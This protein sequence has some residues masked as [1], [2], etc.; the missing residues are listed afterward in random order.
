MFGLVIRLPSEEQLQQALLDEAFG[1]VIHV[2][3]A[4]QVEPQ[5]LEWVAPS[6]HNGVGSSEGARR[7][8]NADD[9]VVAAT[10]SSR[11]GS[12]SGQALERSSAL[13]P[14]FPVPEDDDSEL[15]EADLEEEEEEEEEG[16]QCE[17]C[18]GGS[19]GKQHSLIQHDEAGFHSVRREAGLGWG[20]G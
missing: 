1:S 4:T 20:Q 8:E 11:A 14:F 15:E 3:C 13:S 12:T 19:R 9:D 10:S 18:E 16:G 7:S 17:P 2:D 6:P 5:Y